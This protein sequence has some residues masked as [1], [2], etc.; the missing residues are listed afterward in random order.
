MSWALRERSNSNP[1]GTGGRAFHGNIRR[2]TEP[3]KCKDER[4]LRSPMWNCIGT[5]KGQ[6]VTGLKTLAGAW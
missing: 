2:L 1:W 6:R 4:T 3:M 5:C